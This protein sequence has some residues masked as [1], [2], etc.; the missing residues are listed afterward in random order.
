MGVGH[1]HIFPLV[2]PCPHA[3]W[4]HCPPLASGDDPLGD[5]LTTVGTDADQPVRGGIEHNAIHSHHR[6]TTDT[7]LRQLA[8]LLGGHRCRAHTL[9]K[10]GVPLGPN[11]QGGVD[12]S[13]R[14]DVVLSGQPV[15]LRPGVGKV[16]LAQVEGVASKPRTHAIRHLTQA[17]H[18]I[19]RHGVVVGLQHSAQLPILPD[20]DKRCL[21][22]GQLG[23]QQVISQAATGH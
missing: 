2:V 9:G 4:L 14:H 23:D 21:G 5:H 6:A 1:G 18:A 3:L 10:I 11:H 20:I 22:N 12:G 16:R 13:D 19:R 7:G 17:T 8:E 15:L